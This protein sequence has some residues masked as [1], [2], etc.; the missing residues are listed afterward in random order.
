ML[1]VHMMP[2][3]SRLDV[4]VVQPEPLPGFLS[5]FS[6]K[7]ENDDAANR[8]VL[9]SNWKPARCV[10]MSPVR[11]LGAALPG[12]GL[13]SW[14][15]WL[16][17]WARVLCA[18]SGPVSAVPELLARCCGSPCSFHRRSRWAWARSGRHWTDGVACCRAL[19]VCCLVQLQ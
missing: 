6:I 13:H 14:H 3:R 1:K 9:G 4:G 12:E 7:I 8:P 2:A 17:A 15:R 10:S 16:R 19:V 18:P 5:C 11:W